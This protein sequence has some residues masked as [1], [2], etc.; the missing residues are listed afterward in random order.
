MAPLA[1]RCTPE[2]YLPPVHTWSPFQFSP[3]HSHS[4]SCSRKLLQIAVLL[5]FVLVLPVIVVA[6]RNDNVSVFHAEADLVV[7]DV[8]AVDK[9]GVP[10]KVSPDQWHVLENGVEQ[11]IVSVEHA[12]AATPLPVSLA[13]PGWNDNREQQRTPANI[14]NTNLILFDAVNMTP[15]DQADARAFVMKSLRELPG[16]ERFMLF[17]L[18]GNLKQI[19]GTTSDLSKIE[20]LLK[21]TGSQRLQLMDRDPHLR[22]P[23]V[24]VNTAPN[25][26]MVNGFG[27]FQQ[28]VNV[29]NIDRRVEVSLAALQQIADIAKS[30]PGRKSLIWITA[31]IPMSITSGGSVKTPGSERISVADASSSGPK[32]A[33]V[34]DADSRFQEFE[35]TK[36]FSAQ[37]QKA[38]LKLAEGRVAVYPILSSTL[39]S[40]MTA[41]QANAPF[42]GRGQTLP[43]DLA[44]DHNNP[45]VFNDRTDRIAAARRT[46]ETTGGRAT[47]NSNDIAG[48]FK[49][50]VGDGYEYY[51]ISF[52]PA[53]KNFDGSFRKIEV[54]TTIPGVV[55][56][57]R[58]GYVASRSKNAASKERLQAALSMGQPIANEL[59]AACKLRSGGEPELQMRVALDGLTPEPLPNGK[60]RLS[61]LVGYVAAPWKGAP[62][63]SIAPVQLTLTDEQL[64]SAREKGIPLT[65]RPQIPAAKYALRAGVLDE[66]SKHVGTVDVDTVPQPER[67]IL[68]TEPPKAIDGQELYPEMAELTANAYTN[69]YFALRMELPT[70]K[71]TEALHLPVMPEGRHA[72]LALRFVG[73]NGGSRL[74]AVVSANRNAADDLEA[75]GTLVIFSAE[76]EMLAT[77]DP[78]QAAK[79]EAAQ[80]ADAT[81]RDFGDGRV[82]VCTHNTT[83]CTLYVFLQRRGQ[84][85]KIVAS[86]DDPVM[87]QRIAV[88]ASTINSPLLSYRHLPKQLYTGPTVPT[89]LVQHALDSHMK[90]IDPGTLEN[91]VYRNSQLHLEYGIPKGW[92]VV[93]MDLGT[94][95][96]E[97]LHAPPLEAVE[98]VRQRALFQACSQPLLHLAKNQSAT[99]PDGTE[100]LS[101]FAISPE[102]LSLNVPR[103]W[104]DTRMAGEFADQLST[105]YDFGD[106]RTARQV[107]L[108]GAR[109]IS[110]EGTLSTSL[111]DTQLKKRSSQTLF[112][113]PAG[114]H[115]IG[116]FLYEQKSSTGTAL[117]AF[118]LRIGDTE[119]Q[120]TPAN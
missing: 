18:S 115:L 70:A 102:C 74:T 8:V 75:E 37:I 101:L 53:D 52:V 90:A 57:Y 9:D 6:Q 78:I 113:T 43:A 23:G 116:W 76:N 41:E 111:A 84:L 105:V 92:S 99:G 55:L 91:G 109:F 44:N 103:D 72:L 38:S 14:G 42:S 21:Q 15:S 16:G 29:H 22:D 95:R 59:E 98:K 110:M 48:A 10:V 1:V 54:R 61:L 17:L 24:I 85:L 108:A 80:H 50:A 2:R 87:F 45:S 13:R 106:L 3:V 4:A 120:S 20:E 68:S 32:A 47:F 82:R 88:V 66:P 51:T 63:R 58:P 40:G 33:E 46:A 69:L 96:F 7:V 49:R 30:L 93:P 11:K 36:D 39:N 34:Y 28:L 81:V 35:G 12:G 25:A 89:A 26:A 65:L 62:L 67:A 104:T 64:R 5:T 97:Q 83:G 118:S 60:Y 77:T 112:L 27:I 31:G 107:E 119:A 73:I 79:D 114:D 117:P 19:S 94:A 71:R 86:S 100:I 56:R